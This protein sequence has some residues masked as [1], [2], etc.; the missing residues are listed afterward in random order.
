MHDDCQDLY[1]TSLPHYSHEPTILVLDNLDIIYG[2][3]YD[4]FNQ[5]FVHKKTNRYCNVIYED[6][7]KT[8]LI[9]QKF[10]CFILKNENDLL[11][12]PEIIEKVLPSPL[13]NRFEKHLVNFHNIHSDGKNLLIQRNY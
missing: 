2:A 7:K 3:L 10:K 8:L 12:D 13:M 6:F 5:R 4:L 11:H 1:Y 9:H